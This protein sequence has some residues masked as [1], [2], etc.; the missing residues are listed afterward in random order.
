MKKERSE[1]RRR[2]LLVDDDRVIL[3]TLGQGLQQAG[4]DMVQAV[5]GAEALKLIETEKPDLAVLDVRMPNM[6]GIELAKHLSEHTT[7]PFMFLSAYSNLDVAKQAAEYGAIG[8]LVKPIDTTQLIPALEAALA[9]SDEIKTLRRK[10][11]DLTI[12]L[13]AGR[14]VS[15]AVGV[16][17]ERYKLTREKAFETL[18][19]YARTHQRKLSEVALELIDAAE[20]LNVFQPDQPKN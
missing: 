8:Y 18:R 20:T 3:S 11:S 9:R 1:K 15:I 7:V 13:A 19:L 16:L 6:S 5:S 17:I 10:E 4:Y 12:A 2:I 14:E